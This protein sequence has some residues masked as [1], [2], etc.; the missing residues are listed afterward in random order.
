MHAVCR[1]E[2]VSPSASPSSVLAP[3]P[4]E[5]V[6]ASIDMAAWA[7]AGAGGL[8]TLGVVTVASGPFGAAAV[9]EGRAAQQ[10]ISRLG[11]VRRRTVV[12][13]TSAGG[14]D[15]ARLG[16]PA[17][18]GTAFAVLSSAGSLF[19]SLAGSVRSGWTAE[20]SS[21]GLALTSCCS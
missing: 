9:Q 12:P 3:S 20:L 4:A 14:Q 7:D 21:C 18:N 17:G 6:K 1:A 15:P 8:P 2:Y 16:V 19:S 10:Q 13:F 5:G 11:P